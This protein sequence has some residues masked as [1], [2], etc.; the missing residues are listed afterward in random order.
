[1]FW[2]QFLLM[3]LCF[4]IF[5]GRTSIPLFLPINIDNH[6]KPGDINFTT[7]SLSFQIKLC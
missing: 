1:M 3:L 7:K 6:P 5:P 4:I 2:Q